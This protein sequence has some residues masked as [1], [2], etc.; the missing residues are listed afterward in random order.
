MKGFVWGRVRSV[1]VDG[2]LKSIWGI[3]GRNYE[4]GGWDFVRIEIF[5]CPIWPYGLQEL[6][7][8]KV[9]RFWPRKGRFFSNFWSSPPFYVYLRLR[10][11]ESVRLMDRR[12]PP[13]NVGLRYRFFR[14]IKRG[15]VSGIFLWKY[16]L[17][18]QF[19]QLR[20]RGSS[21]FDISSA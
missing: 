21:D 4:L 19:E 10:F 9:G 17:K 7:L 3:F 5:Q 18:Y 8:L 6:I 15:D 12:L 16:R 20:R 11:S 14:S 1:E 2:F 13:E